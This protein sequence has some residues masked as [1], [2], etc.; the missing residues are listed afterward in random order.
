MPLQTREAADSWQPVNARRGR[1]GSFRR[2]LGEA[3][4]RRDRGFGLLAPSAGAGR[5][6]GLHRLQPVGLGHP[7]AAATGAC[8][9]PWVSSVVPASPETAWPALGF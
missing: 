2:A 5:P 4:P 9:C 1:E 6:W 3:G 7:A 8:C